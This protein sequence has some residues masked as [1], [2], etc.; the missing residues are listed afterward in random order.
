MTAQPPLLY[1]R[2]V[3]AKLGLDGHDVGVNLVARALRDAGAEVIYL[4]KRVPADAIVAAAISEDADAIGVSS[5]S[6]GLG[7][8]A[9]QTAELLRTQGSDIPVLAGGIDEPGE[10][11]RMLSAGVS[12]HFGPGTPMTEILEAFVKAISERGE[13]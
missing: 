9:A 4:G 3:L 2:V 11:E 8:F 13:R 1:K 6:G 7:H 10:I 12:R 5:L